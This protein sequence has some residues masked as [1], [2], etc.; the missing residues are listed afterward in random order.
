[1]YV[2][3]ATGGA[4]TRENCVPERP[5]EAQRGPERQRSPERPREA[6]R[7]PE[8]TREPHVG[9]NDATRKAYLPTLVGIRF[10]G[11]VLWPKP[12]TG[13]WLSFFCFEP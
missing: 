7:G 3:V 4:Q 8:K 10:S 1:M 13:A 2:R 6:Q 11:G 12:P 5:R 9:R